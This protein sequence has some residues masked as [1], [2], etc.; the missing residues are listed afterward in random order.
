MGIEIERKFLVKSDGWRKLGCA[1]RYAQA[2]SR[3]DRTARCACE[4][5]ATR[6][7]SRSR[8]AEAAS[9]I[10][11]TSTRSRTTRP[12]PCSTNSPKSPSSPKPHEDSV[13]GLRLGG[14]RILRRQRGPRHGRDRAAIR[15]CFLREARVDRRGGD[16]RSALLQLDARKESVQKLAA[17]IPKTS[18]AQPAQSQA[19]PCQARRMPAICRITFSLAC[20]SIEGFPMQV[21]Q[22]ESPP[23]SRLPPF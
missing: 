6:A 16:G 22:T 12:G 20:F 1:V 9:R 23:S 2:T 7:F 21:P 5:W 19:S 11:S 3:S 8:D 4:P 13:C 10:P 17:L 14:G 15:G 18:S